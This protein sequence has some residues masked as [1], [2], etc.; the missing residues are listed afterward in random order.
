MTVR[1]VSI[2]TTS[3]PTLVIDPG[4]R[5]EN[6]LMEVD[7]QNQSSSVPVFIGSSAVAAAAGSGFMLSPSTNSTV[8][9]YAAGLMSG[10][11][12]WAASTA[13]ATVVALILRS[14]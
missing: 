8:N 2:T 13:A 6:D 5:Y 3:N 12:I 10:D 14:T 1:T 7:I 4:T 11:A 9:A